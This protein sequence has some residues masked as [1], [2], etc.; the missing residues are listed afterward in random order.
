MTNPLVI[1]VEVETPSVALERDLDARVIVVATPGPP[2][3]NGGGTVNTIVAGNNID[4]DATDLANPIVSVEA[5]TATDITDVTATAAELNHTGGVTSGI[6]T[7]LDGKVDENAP[8]TGA[9]KTK[10]TYDAKGLVTAGAN[11]TQDDIG[12]GSANK[13]YSA[14]E[15]TKLAGVAAGATANDTDANLKAR[16]N[17]TGTQAASTIA[18]FSSAA[19]ARITAA[20]G[21][22]I[23]AYD[24]DLAAIAGLTSA[25]NK[26]PY[27]TGAGAWAVT[28]LSSF[29]RTV[30][31]DTTGVAARTTLGAATNKTFYVDDYGADPTGSTFS[32]TAVAAAVT[33]L[34]SSAGT[35]EFG[36]G[37]YK[38][39]STTIT[40]GPYQSVIGDSLG[41]TVLK[42]SGTGDC[43]RVR[44]TRSFSTAE[45]ALPGGTSG[46][47]FAGKITSLTI[48]GTGAGSVAHGVHAGDLSGHHINGV[49]VVNFTGASAIGFWFDN[50]ET[51]Y[52]RANVNAEVYN[53]TNAVV[54][55]GGNGGAF[56]FSFLYST[57]RFWLSCNANQNG[58]VLRGGAEISHATLQVGGNFWGHATSN[59]G[60]VLTLGGSGDECGLKRSQVIIAVETNGDGPV[61]HKTLALAG[62]SKINNCYGQLQYRGGGHSFTNSGV[63]LSGS[64]GQSFSG[65]ID[66]DGDIGRT[67]ESQGLRVLGLAT[68]TGGLLDSVGNL[69]LGTGNWFNR[70]M[71]AG[72]QTITIILAT[73]LSWQNGAAFDL[74]IQQPASGTTTLTWPGSFVWLNGAAPVLSTA[75]NA[76][77]HIH[78]TT[79][80]FTTF[81]A[82]HVNAGKQSRSVLAAS[83]T[84][85]LTVGNAANVFTG[86][87]ATTWT[88]PPIAGTKGSEIFIKNRGSA[89]LTVQRAGAD[90]IYST[91]AVTSVTVAA[92]ASLRPINDGAFWVVP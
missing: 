50:T 70:Q 27:A 12:D 73:D 68:G 86:G 25:A 47:G 35:I 66:V 88:L 15:K 63:F 90:Q 16:A 13:Q 22:T 51:W 80:D 28:D 18:D 84:Q 62:S 64:P 61:G 23:Q 21:S 79:P 5:L 38:L 2:G 33:A 36:P 46:P 17:H 60:T 41:A 52:E 49:A 48:D 71:T 14:T 92:G 56:S 53:C 6:Q 69:Y 30:L 74:F 59:T 77:D 19:D 10:I 89:T 29:A 32:D 9:S 37:I 65:I 26:L 87:S 67:D 45:D 85:T 4:V 78:V 58:V 44:D 83:T 20:V 55:D 3:T 75:N 42:Y 40:L 43:I 7:Q 31:D 24:A 34:G 57:Y 82:E 8:I 54:F 91:S 76:V 72:A 39:A 1:Q 81:Y 11:A